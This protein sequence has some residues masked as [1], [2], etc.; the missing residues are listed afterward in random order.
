MELENR[1]PIWYYNTHYDEDTEE[2]IEGRQEIID[3]IQDKIDEL[4]GCELLF[5]SGE[6]I[7]MFDEIIYGVN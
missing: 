7:K 4:D 6:V 2:K 5:T 1:T 3:R